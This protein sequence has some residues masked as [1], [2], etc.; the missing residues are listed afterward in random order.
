MLEAAIGR[1]LELLV[2]IVP[3]PFLRYPTVVEA[4]AV[5]LEYPA[6]VETLVSTVWKTPGRAAAMAAT[7]IFE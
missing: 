6:A 1:H 3:V 4:N 7:F 5:V 2:E